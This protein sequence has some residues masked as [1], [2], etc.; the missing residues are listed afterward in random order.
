MSTL[1]PVAYRDLELAFFGLFV[2]AS[3][4]T[5]DKIRSLIRSIKDQNP[6]DMDT[7]RNW[8]VLFRVRDPTW[9]LIQ[10]TAKNRDP[11]IKILTDLVRVFQIDPTLPTAKCVLVRARTRWPDYDKARSHIRIRSIL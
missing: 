7:E 8:E 1:T 2:N 3:A 11:A 4:E 5:Q 6:K 9:A 10:L